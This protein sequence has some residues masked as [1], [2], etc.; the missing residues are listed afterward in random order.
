MTRGAF[1]CRCGKPVFFRNSQCLA[2]KAPLGYEPE[3][4]IIS[5]LEPAGDSETWRLAGDGIPAPYYR[6][7]NL[8]VSGCNWLVKATAGDMQAGALCLCCRLDRTIPDLSLPQNAENFRRISIAKRR[9]VSLLASLG[10]PLA[11][12]IDQDTEHGLAF[13]MLRSLDGAPPVMTG[14]SDGIITLN[15]DEADDANR[16]RIRDQMGEPYRTV[17]GHLRH[18]VGHY[19]WDRLIL[20]TPWIGEFRKVF[21]DDQQDYDAALQT[22]Y[23]NGPASD[24]QQCFVSAY[25]SSHPWE[26]WAESWAHYLHIADTFATALSFGLDPDASLDVE[27]EPFAADSL[28]DGNDPDA[29]AFLRFI[30]SWIRL[31]APFNELSRAMGLADFYPF[32]LSRG[33]V[34]KL[35][36]VHIVVAQSGAG[37][38]RSLLQFLH[39]RAKN[40]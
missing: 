34:A 27:I 10:L 39:S 40:A 38:A 1:L 16:E 17:L 26:D 3:L 20:G 6:C 36:F 9:L 7:A 25:A 12:R 19:Y 18:E 31:T 21:G 13:D 11:S 35:H 4:G 33:A 5:A 15:V 29:D 24:W 37:A 28:Y 14:H 22:Y 30:N 2:C 23:Q 8:T 32:V